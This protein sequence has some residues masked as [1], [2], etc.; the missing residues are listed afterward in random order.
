MSMQQASSPDFFRKDSIKF[1]RP[2]SGR[3]NFFRRTGYRFKLL[4]NPRTPSA[5]SPVRRTLFGFRLRLSSIFF[6]VKS[7][8][9]SEVKY[10]EKRALSAPDFRRRFRS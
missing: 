3:P 10:A 4:F 5:N 2:S 6:L 8:K 7:K 9:A 1:S